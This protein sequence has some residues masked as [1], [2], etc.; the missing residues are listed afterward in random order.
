MRLVAPAGVRLVAPAG[1]RLVAPAGVRLVALAGVRVTTR[2]VER[3][4]RHLLGGRPRF[5]PGLLQERGREER[6][7]DR[8]EG[9]RGDPRRIG[10]AIGGLVHDEAGTDRKEREPEQQANEVGRVTR[11]HPFPPRM[12]SMFPGSKR[13]TV[14]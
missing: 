11:H 14:T 5:A 12:V 13:R 3:L 4:G 9:D 2:L 7:T 8:D 10:G 6:D 1:V